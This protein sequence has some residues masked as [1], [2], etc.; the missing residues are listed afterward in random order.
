MLFLVVAIILI[1]ILFKDQLKELALRE[2]N[3]MLKADVA[4][5]DFDLTF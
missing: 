5:G 2:A 4:V 3:K 1:P